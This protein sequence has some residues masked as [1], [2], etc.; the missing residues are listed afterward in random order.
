MTIRVLVADDDPLIRQLI[1][2]N[3]ELEGYEVHPAADGV[4]ALEVAARVGPSAATVD[5]M[6]PRLDGFAVAAALREDP[7]TAGIKICLVSARAQQADR[8]RAETAPGVD[9]YVAKP[10]DP[11]DLV[12]VVRR[13]AGG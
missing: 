4:E 8:A 2:M 7:A 1:T 13:L 11:D 3:L 5:V 6:M 12:G 9:A 10:F